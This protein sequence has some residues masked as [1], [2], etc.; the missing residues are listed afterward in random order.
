MGFSG[1][2]QFQTQNAATFLA[3]NTPYVLLP[4]LLLARMRMPEPFTR[5]F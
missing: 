4:I 5:K 3:F 1:E 2:P